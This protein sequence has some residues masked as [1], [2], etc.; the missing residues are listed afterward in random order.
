MLIKEYTLGFGFYKN[1]NNLI[2][3]LYIDDLF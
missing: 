1:K 2:L 3:I